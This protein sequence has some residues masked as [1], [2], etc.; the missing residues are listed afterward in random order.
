MIE[1]DNENIFKINLTVLAYLLLKIL[2]QIEW[3]PEI[4]I[5]MTP[6]LHYYIL[7]HFPTHASFYHINKY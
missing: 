7:Y 1:K 4:L 3:K 5:N 2:Y 6:T